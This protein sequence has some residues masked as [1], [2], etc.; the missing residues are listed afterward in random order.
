MIEPWTQTFTGQRFDT[1][2]PKPMQFNIRDI[3]V[4]LSRIC[5]FNGH[6]KR[7]YSVAEHCI[8]MAT[9]LRNLDAPISHAYAALMHDLSEA[10]LPDMPGPIKVHFPDFIAAEDLIMQRAANVFGFE[11]PLPAIVKEFDRRILI[12]ERD[13]AMA[14]PP[15][16]WGITGEPLGVKLMF[17]APSTAA[18]E[19]RD[20]YID[21][22]R[23][24]T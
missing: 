23:H 9:H 14:K 4:A 12:D 18:A 2:D 6:T 20:L 10:Y 13:Q 7:H 22:R 16:E 8:L 5:R 11:W 3:A 1:F 24:F 21:L 15:S 17:L 19:F